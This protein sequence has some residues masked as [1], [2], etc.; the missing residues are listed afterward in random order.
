[1]IEGWRQDY[2]HLRPHSSLGALTPV[3][4]A[5]LNGLK[6]RGSSIEGRFSA[7]LDG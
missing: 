7:P 3:E 1:M 4:F 2:N 6:F 5:A